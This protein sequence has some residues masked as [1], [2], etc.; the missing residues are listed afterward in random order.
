MHI[1]SEA[2]SVIQRFQ[3]AAPV[4][5]VSLAGAFG[6]NVWNAS[7]EDHISGKLTRNDP[8]LSGV[9][10]FA[11]L[12]NNAHPRNRQRFT[13]AHEIGHFILHRKL[14]DDGDVVD[15]TFYRSRFPSRIETEANE[16]AAEILMPFNLIRIE[17]DRGLVTPEALAERFGVSEAAMRIRLGLP[18]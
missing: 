9:S 3:Q 15:D 10:G 1:P 4:R 18:T 5:V 7:M 17:T 2:L 11:I 6:I 13:I 12:V 8:K 14:L 16:A